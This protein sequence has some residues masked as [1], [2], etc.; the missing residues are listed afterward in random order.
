MDEVK[1]PFEEGSGLVSTWIFYLAA[2]WLY[3]RETVGSRDVYTPSAPKHGERDFA[4]VMKSSTLRWGGN[5]FDCWLN[6]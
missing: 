6:F 5:P 1:M 2:H 3:G 4:D